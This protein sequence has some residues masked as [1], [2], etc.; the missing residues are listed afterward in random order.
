MSEEKK[1]VPAATDTL[2]MTNI[3]LVPAN[4]NDNETGSICQSDYEKCRTCSKEKACESPQAGGCAEY[5]EA[6]KELP[7][8]M[9]F[10]EEDVP[11][12]ISYLVEGL[13]EENTLCA[14]T[15]ESGCGKSFFLLALLYS[16][17]TGVEF[18]GREVSQGQVVYILGEG[19]SGIKRRQLAWEKKNGVTIPHRAFLKSQQPAE[20]S[21][22]TYAEKV[23]QS[24]DMMGVK[25]RVIAIDTLN[26]NF[27]PGDENSTKDMTAFILSC[28]RLQAHYS[29]TVIMAHHTGHGQDRARGSSVYRASL[30]L[31]VMLKESKVTC[32]KSKDSE[33]FKDF[34]FQIV[35]QVI[36]YDT[37]AGVIEFTECKPEIKLGKQASQA[38]AILEERDPTR[39]GLAA[40]LPRGFFPGVSAKETNKLWR[41]RGIYKQAHNSAMKA[42]T[43]KKLLEEHVYDGQLFYALN[44]H[45]LAR[46]KVVT[47]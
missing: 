7:F 24:I 9:I 18:A 43:D 33:P 5:S 22:P 37:K 14:I 34:G 30:D 19:H 25:P 41:E 1:S 32:G 11:R 46:V 28:K 17:C 26:M 15:G 47:K 45:E 39:K 21:D 44:S 31:E 10:A 8:P 40:E 13:I 42:L 38:L 3:K 36:D 2:S 29:C 4:I 20:L 27:G 16:V 6:K 23:I 12:G 35:D